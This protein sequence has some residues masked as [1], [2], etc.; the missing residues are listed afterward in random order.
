M[1]R[2]AEFSSFVEHLS[3][4]LQATIVYRDMSLGQ[5]VRER[6][7]VGILEAI[8]RDA[9]PDGD[10][11]AK[12]PVGKVLQAVLVASGVAASR[13]NI[14]PARY[15]PKRR[16]TPP[17]GAAK[18]RKLMAKAED[19]DAGSGEEGDYGEGT[20][21]AAAGEDGESDDGNGS[22]FENTDSSSDSGS[23]SV[24]ASEDAEASGGTT[25]VSS[26]ASG[27]DGGDPRAEGAADA[28]NAEQATFTADQVAKFVLDATSKLRKEIAAINSRQQGLLARV[29]EHAKALDVAA[30]KP[31]GKRDRD[32]RDAA[33]KNPRRGQ[34]EAEGMPEDGAK[35]MR[36]E[37][38][39]GAMDRFVVRGNGSPQP[40]TDHPAEVIDV[41]S[42][43]NPAIPR[44][45]PAAKKRAREATEEQEGAA[46][47]RREDGAG[48]GDVDGDSDRA[49]A[50]ERLRTVV[51]SKVSVA[52]PRFGI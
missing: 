20:E 3:S 22:V 1:T 46:A 7:A 37:G 29:T 31:S 48:D 19:E 39:V 17:K 45:S 40:Q 51:K 25:S 41:A 14:T 28:R 18:P 8:A 6:E 12:W 43:V 35:P 5:L 33:K 10:D 50:Q 44:R 11:V 24:G 27:E 32:G 15:M 42:D 36:T 16:Q 9:A 26:E 2:A 4:R 38:Q 52:P 47:P 13:T 21:G 34:G 23:G 30:K 49:Q